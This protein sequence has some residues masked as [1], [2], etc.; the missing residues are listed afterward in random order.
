MR[1]DERR[2]V[3][4]TVNNLLIKRCNKQVNEENFGGQ[5]DIDIKEAF[6]VLHYLLYFSCQVMSWFSIPESLTKFTGLVSSVS[7]Q[8]KTAIDQAG[9][10]DRAADKSKDYDLG[11][12]NCPPWVS[13]NPELKKHEPELKILI[14]QIT[15]RPPQDVICS[16]LQPVPPNSQFDFD[17]EEES[18]RA[19]AAIRSDP[20]LDNIRLQLVSRGERYSHAHL[21]QRF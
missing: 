18:P 17:F 15:D 10:S 16:F 4:T 14:L 19:L 3:A 11:A 21:T 6:V 8:I 13:E 2:G 12:S 7:D 1:W 9:S 5:I 20:L